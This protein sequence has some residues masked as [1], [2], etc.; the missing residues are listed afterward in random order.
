MI[1]TPL[2]LCAVWVL[3]A[4][5]TAFLPMRHQYAP[6]LTLLVLAP[7]LIIWAALVHGWWIAVVGV[8]AFVSMFRNPLRYFWRRARGECPEIPR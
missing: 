1:S 7:V 5:A 2:V 6:G 4:S 3:A 8:L